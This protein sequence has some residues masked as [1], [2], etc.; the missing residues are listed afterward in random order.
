MIDFAVQ[1]TKMIDSQVRTEDVTDREVIAAMGAVARERFVPA[2]LADLA[3]IDQDL[4]IAGAGAGDR[5]L[6]KPA[7]LAR[8]LQAADVESSDRVLD[9]GCGTGYAAA[10][11]AGLAAEVVALEQEATL[12]AEARKQL[13]GLANV[14]VVEGPLEAG[15]KAGAPYDLILVEGAV[16]VVPP[17][18]LEQLAE[19]GKLVTVVGYGRAAAATVYTRADGDVGDRPVFDAAAPALPGFRK[20]KAFVFPL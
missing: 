10:V 6:L 18:L 17:A 2:R 19:G 16:E 1:R 20:P 11:L 12:A 9:V 3:Y 7:T 15:H 4:P 13:A 8:L 14:Q 5:F